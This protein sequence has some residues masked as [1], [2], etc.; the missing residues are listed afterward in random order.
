[1]S[2]IYRGCAIMSLATA[3]CLSCGAASAQTATG[4]S[5]GV[6]PQAGVAGDGSDIIVT[7]QRRSERLQ[8]VPASI[9]ALSADAL[10]KS[11]VQNTAELAKTVPGITMTFYGSFLQPSIRGVTSTGANLGEN[12]NV[13]LYLDGVYQPQQIA[14]LIDL[15]DVEQIEVLKGPQ[16]ALYGQNATGGAIL[17]ASK[18]PSFTTEGLLSASYGNFD[19][20]N[21]RGYVSTP[22][23]D[24][25]AASISG[26]YQDRDGFRRFVINGQRDRGLNAK[27][28][29]GKLLLEPVETAK[30]TLTGF[31]SNRIDSAMYAGFAINGNSIGYAASLA[32]LG[33]PSL[34]VPP[35][36]KVTSTKQ[37]S[38]D[39]DVFTRIKSTGGSMRVEYDVGAGTI[40]ST[41]AYSHNRI[42]YLSDADFTAV[43]I[44]V[45]TTDPLTGQYFTH[46]TNFV[47]EK[48]GAFSF[49]VG[50]FYL[51]GNEAFHNNRFDLFV[52]TAPPTPKIVI[53]VSN[54]NARV[55]KEIFAG[56][57]EL[58]F[59]ATD[60]LVIT[61]GGRYTRERQRAF[62][63][64]AI[65]APGAGQTK[66][67]NLVEYP[68]G[69]VVFS[70]FT[71]RVTARY[72]VTPS[73]NVYASW[74][75]GFKSGVIN[76]TNYTIAPVKP[77]VIDAYEIGYKGRPLDTVRFNI[78]GFLYDYKNLQSVVF[79]P[80]QA[81]ITQNAAT[82]RV[83]GVDFDLS[84]SVTPEFTLSGGGSFLDG[85]YRRFPGAA[86]YVP[87]GTG[88]I[89]STIDLSG[90]R[91]LRSPKFSGNIAA[92][93]QIETGAG[94]LAAYGSI[95]HTSSY[96][97]E[98]TGRLRQG[99]YTTADAE[100][101]FQ[102]D[103]VAGLRLVVWGKNLTD[104]AYLASALVAAGLAD[105]GSYAEPRT[106]GVR[107][108]F[109]F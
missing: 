84:W 103:A 46:E 57:G 86:N 61:A 50:G 96:G 71:P 22:I 55:D 109:K 35:S 49:L 25:I 56:Y 60:E 82:A 19:A 78:A 68:G 4:P 29:R 24:K 1:M 107:A 104:K 51:N 34:A 15:P 65:F 80:G 31:Y 48:F 17:V 39:P 18:A 91:M 20:V 2:R 81:Y 32:G 45:S 83:K 7:A 11:G 99:A 79:V 76:T 97:M 33:I 67:P 87:T 58:T 100:L 75:R 43:N 77:E 85:K 13:A 6:T 90:R 44:G 89:P 73:S 53:P 40:N 14:T 63:D 101:S 36:P 8:D 105:G 66:V 41:T 38:T 5:A 54:Q 98:P 108:E 12:S 28:V 9:T 62:T 10:S 30:I 69:S 59:Q 42:T 70:K 102:P 72:E 47:S 93:Y 26:G 106:Y 27:V 37:F 74:G 95:F 64:Q 21:V 92:N 16:G 3:L 88:H 23:S 94:I 52:P